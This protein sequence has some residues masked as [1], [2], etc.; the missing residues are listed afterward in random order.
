MDA[1]L[2]APPRSIDSPSPTCCLMGTFLLVDARIQSYIFFPKTIVLFVSVPLG[3][4]DEGKERKNRRWA[5]A[6]KKRSG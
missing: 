1:W 2:S 6:K 5:V 4:A 3:Y